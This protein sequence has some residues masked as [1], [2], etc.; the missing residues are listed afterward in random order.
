[1]ATHREYADGSD[2]V[3]SGT[4]YYFEQ[5]GEVTIEREDFL[6]NA[7][8]VE[9]THTDTSGNWEPYPEFGQYQSITRE[10]R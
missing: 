2:K 10:N 8:S 9:V 6:R 4:T 1:M 7:R 3:K 5:N